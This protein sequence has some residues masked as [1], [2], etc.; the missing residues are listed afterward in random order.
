MSKITEM[1]GRIVSGAYYDMQEVRIS[2]KNRIRD[3][4]RK[5]AEGIAFDAVEEKK[6]DRDFKK[7][8]TDK[9]L[10]NMWDDLLKKKEITEYEYKYVQMCWKLA[11]DSE[12]IEDKY[13]DRM[14]EYVSQE[15]TYVEFLKK[16]RGIGPVIS[17]NLLKE[18][19]TCSQYDTVSALWCHT[20]NHVNGDGRAPKRHKGQKFDPPLRT[21]TWKISNNLMKQN[22]GLYRKYYDDAKRRYLNRVYPD[23]E[24]EA[25]YGKPYKKEDTKLSK[26]HAHNMALRVMRKVFLA[27]YYGCAREMADLDTRETYVKEKLGH[28]GVTTWKDAVRWEGKYKV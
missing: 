2:T 1:L 11:D 20:G 17:A 15:N 7:K 5:K 6:E 3:I 27:H 8:Y 10:F 14:L 18:F 23:G 24:L 4:I 9:Q 28:K 26:G 19:G 22:K 13:K 25:K 21:F 16:V 12:K